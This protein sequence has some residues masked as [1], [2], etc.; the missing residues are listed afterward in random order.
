VAELAAEKK[1]AVIGTPIEN[2]L[3]YIGMNVKIPPFDNVKVR[4]AVAYAI[5]YRKIMM[6]TGIAVTIQAVA[7]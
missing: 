4:Q 3:V 2:A 5:P 1:L 6:S 7:T